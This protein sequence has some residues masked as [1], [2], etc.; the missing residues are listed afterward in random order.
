MKKNALKLN[1][2]RLRWVAAAIAIIAVAGVSGVAMAKEKKARVVTSGGETGNGYIGVYMQDLTDD[3]RKGLDLEVSKGVLVSGVE[4][5][6]PA[7]LAGVEEGDV[8]VKFNG[9]AV[10]SPD[11]LRDAVSAVAPGKTAQVELVR[12][13]KSKTMTITVGERPEQHS[14]R[15]YSGDDDTGAMHIARK[16]AMLGGPRLGVQAHELEDDGLASYFGARK[17]EGLLVL[18]VDEESVAGKAGV[19][20]GDIINRVGDETIADVQDVREALRDYDEGDQFDITV[21]RHGKSQSLKATMDDQTHEF[22]FT[23]PGHDRHF[24]MLAPRP[25]RAPRAPRVWMQDES[26]DLRREL[27]GLK[28]ELKELKEELEDRNDG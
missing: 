26:D 23:M 20:P 7:A 12:E 28:K 3:V 5:D 22:A 6:A 11:E 17:G 19:K 18:S 24:Q 21:L 8:I 2:T 25:P 9:N 4:D 16:F 10:T 14:F 27:D 1:A 15:W 13:G